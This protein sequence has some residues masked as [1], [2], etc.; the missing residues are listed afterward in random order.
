[1]QITSAGQQVLEALKLDKASDT[2][3]IFGLFNAVSLFRETR[4][5]FLNGSEFPTYD[6]TVEEYR[7]VV[8]GDRHLRDEDTQLCLLGDRW[9]NDADDI[10]SGNSLKGEGKF[11]ELCVKFSQT[12]QFDELFSLS[13]LEEAKTKMEAY[14]VERQKEWDEAY[15]KEKSDVPA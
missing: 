5:K 14:H 3:K 4:V 15:R 7:C 2:V 12:E 6:A 9:F 1:M 8:F 10:I 11:S 13:A